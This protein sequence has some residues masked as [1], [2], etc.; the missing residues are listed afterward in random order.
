[1]EIPVLLRRVFRYRQIRSPV[2]PHGQRHWN[3]DL[4]DGSGYYDIFSAL[5]LCGFGD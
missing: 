1:M 5:Q 4:H 2:R 3:G